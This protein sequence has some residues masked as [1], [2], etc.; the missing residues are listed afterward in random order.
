MKEA[1]HD[2]SKV[3]GFTHQFYRYPAR[4]SPVFAR[5][6]IEAFSK[7]G[8][9]VL[10]PYMGGG[11]TVLEAMSHGRQAVGS[12]INS[13]AVF[14][15]K[16]KITRLSELDRCYLSKWAD[17]IPSLR[18][19]EWINPSDAELSHRPR[20]LNLPSVKWH[21]KL[22]ATCLKSIDE[23]LPTDNSRQ[24]ARCVL[25]NVGQWAL[26]GR[27]RL[28]TVDEFRL[29]LQATY[30]I[31]LEGMN[32]LE[33]HIE[34]QGSDLYSPIVRQNDAAKIHT[35]QAIQD[36]GPVDLVVT[37]PPYPGIHM[38]YHR[39]QVDGRKE[40]DAP[41]WIAGCNDGDGATHYN[42]AGRKGAGVDRYFQKATE[43]FT[44]IRSVMKDGAILVQMIAFSEPQRQLARYLNSMREAG[45]N[46]IRLEGR[47]R[48]WRQVP[49]RRWHANLKG[50]TS[51]SRE[52]VLV[53]RAA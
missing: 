13:L 25:L 36:T 7:P 4:F 17:T 12:D 20:N 45:F 16:A 44:S 8:D 23:F 31:M 42:F 9:I 32:E 41:Y 53:H 46:E 5:A 34:V 1:A 14:V 37:S 26:N 43:T 3:A 22:I 33:Q 29:K 47:Y 11:T 2:Q 21:R 24:F 48:T 35:D 30:Q 10:D 49:G 50:K 39:W 19:T 38:L 52:V 40:T 6:A 28:P 51:S 15:A 18:C 27:R